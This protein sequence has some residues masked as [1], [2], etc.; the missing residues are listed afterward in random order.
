M[1]NIDEINT[2]FLKPNQVHDEIEDGEYIA[3]VSNA[4]IFN[5]KNNQTFC[6]LDFLISS[7]G[8][9]NNFALSKL[10]NLEKNGIKSLKRDLNYMQVKTNVSIEDSLEKSKGVSVRLEVVEV[11][12]NNK[13]Y[14]NYNILG[15]NIYADPEYVSMDSS[16]DF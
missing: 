3:E 9:Y 2:L 13:K 15:L 11:D 6:R 12:F 14:K 4:K 5:S 1:L 7:E 16:V 10:Y 8:K